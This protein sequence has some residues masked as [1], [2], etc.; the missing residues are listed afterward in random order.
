MDKN[1]LCTYY[2]KVLLQALG[3]WMEERMIHKQLLGL[4]LGTA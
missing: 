4:R 3:Q 2:V 1:T